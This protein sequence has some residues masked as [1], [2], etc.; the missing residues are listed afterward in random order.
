MTTE[1]REDPFEPAPEPNA[2]A[3]AAPAPAPA[4]K[5][6]WRE[7]RWQRRRRRRMFEEILGWILVPIILIA[8][9]WAVVG[10]LN[11]AGTSPSAIIQG[12]RQLM[13]G[14]GAQP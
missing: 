3:Q 7:Q 2:P 8:G 1:T 14:G 13:T 6:T 11:A 4:R 9:Y 10:G 5:L 12:I